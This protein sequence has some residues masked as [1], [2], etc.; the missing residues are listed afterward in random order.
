MYSDIPDG[1]VNTGGT[2]G[3]SAYLEDIVSDE[4]PLLDDVETTPPPNESNT[5]PPESSVN[6]WVESSPSKE[7]LLQMMEKVDRDITA[8]EQQISVLEKRQV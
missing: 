1:V 2:S 7:E 5:P 6:E 8:I 4:E 3:L